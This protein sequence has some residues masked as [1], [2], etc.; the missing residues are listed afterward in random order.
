MFV[1]RCSGVGAVVYD[2]RCRCCGVSKASVFDEEPFAMLSGKQKN[3][4]NDSEPLY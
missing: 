2:G 3:H 4:S 1:V